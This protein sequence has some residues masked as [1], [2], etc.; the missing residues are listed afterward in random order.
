MIPILVGVE[1]KNWLKNGFSLKPSG[2]TISIIYRL[3][4]NEKR[5]NLTCLDLQIVLVDTPL[6]LFKVNANNTIF[7]VF[8]ELFRD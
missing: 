8:I 4:A 6:E 5:Y 3:K 7:G 2:G 1:A